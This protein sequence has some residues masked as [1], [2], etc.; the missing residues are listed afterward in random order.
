MGDL[1]V[2]AVRKRRVP[3]HSGRLRPSGIAADILAHRV[4]RQ[5][6]TLDGT[7]QRGRGTEDLYRNAARGAAPPTLLGC[8]TMR[9]QP[10]QAIRLLWGPV[11][12]RTQRFVP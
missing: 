5:R 3:R 8:I 9:A 4:Q 7:G 6:A 11:A 2:T 1:S 10:D 12:E